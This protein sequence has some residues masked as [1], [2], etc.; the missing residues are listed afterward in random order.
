M[1]I[2]PDKEWQ[3]WD[4]KAVELSHGQ[5]ETVA[6]TAAK[7]K[8]LQT[9]VI[10]VFATVTFAGGLTTLDKLD[11]PYHWIALGITL[12]AVASALAAVW[13][14]SAAGGGLYTKVATQP[15]DGLDLKRQWA[16]EA[17]RT[18]THLRRGQLATAVTIGLFVVGAV[19]VLVVGPSTGSQNY[20]A[21][22]TGKAPA[23]GTL[24][25]S[26]DGTITIGAKEDGSGGQKLDASLISVTPVKASEE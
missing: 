14:L 1:P 25:V 2:D 20:I 13:L 17:K 18:N 5:R 19:L 7:W 6:A 22:F 9:A 23:Y 4:D 11:E 15:L 3:Y 16:D 24:S 21:T 12:A 26:K 8:A 10:A